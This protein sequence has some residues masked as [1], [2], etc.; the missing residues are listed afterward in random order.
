[1][2]GKGQ[3]EEKCVILGHDKNDRGTQINLGSFF[4][5]PQNGGGFD[6][7]M[8]QGANIL[9]FGGDRSFSLA[10]NRAGFALGSNNGALVGGQRVGVDG[11]IGGGREG[12]E[13]GSQVQFGNEP[14]PGHPAG[15]FGSFLDN[16]KNF[17]SFLGRGMPMPPQQPPPSPPFS[18]GV[19]PTPPTLIG[20]EGAAGE[21]GGRHKPRPWFPEQRPEER[22]DETD[23][24]SE[25]RPKEGEV[26]SLSTEE[27]ELIGPNNGE[28]LRK[29]VEFSVD[30]EPEEF[31][32]DLFTAQT[33]RPRELPGLVEFA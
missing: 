31:T 28:V 8:G 5:H 32:E 1:M 16:M 11:G 9:G 23:M 18:L 33:S 25:I 19:T 15:Q 17:F 7:G 20:T 12:V 4:L 30:R 21:N 14:N 10:G 24:G 27:A 22:L 6:M 13:M 3:G 2:N 29:S 26:K